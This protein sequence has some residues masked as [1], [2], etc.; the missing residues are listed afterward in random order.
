MLKGTKYYLT[1]LKFSSFSVFRKKQ[2]RT[3]RRGSLGGSD[4][5]ASVSELSVGSRSGRG[6]L[7]RDPTADAKPIS[8]PALRSKL[9]TART[10][11]A[12]V[13]SR[14]SIKTLR[15]DNLDNSMSAF[16]SLL[17]GSMLCIFQNRYPR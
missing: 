6:L 1:T 2:Q 14:V 11:A 9:G 13:T 3:T 8:S 12:K 7:G 4:K 15:M 5:A 17:F 10:T 16:S